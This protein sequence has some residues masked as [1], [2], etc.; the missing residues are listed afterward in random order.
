MAVKKGFFN[1]F[2][3]IPSSRAL[4]EANDS[5][6]EEAQKV[7]LRLIFTNKTSYCCSVP[8]QTVKHI[9]LSF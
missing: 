6:G 2:S 8:V 1:V 3:K 4:C 9:T 7:I 5:L